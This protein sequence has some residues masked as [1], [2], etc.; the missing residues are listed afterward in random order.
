MV[1]EEAKGE[2]EAPLE[3]LYALFGGDQAHPQVTPAVTQSKARTM[4]LRATEQRAQATAVG[5]AVFE[6]PGL[7]QPP[8]SSPSLPPVTMPSPMV[9]PTPRP[10][11]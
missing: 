4:A 11:K 7:G 3:G 2:L 10:E 8:P 5:P 9:G 6:A 1:V